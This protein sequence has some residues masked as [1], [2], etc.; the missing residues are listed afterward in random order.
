[1]FMSPKKKK[2]KEQKETAMQ[3]T[4]TAMQSME[5]SM[6]STET[7]R[8]STE[9]ARESTEIAIQSMETA[10]QSM[11][12]TM[13]SIKTNV[14]KFSYTVART[15][16]RQGYNL[17]WNIIEKGYNKSAPGKE[18]E[19]SYVT[20]EQ[21][22]SFLKGHILRT[23]CFQSERIFNRRGFNIYL[24]K[25]LYQV[26]DSIKARGVVYS[27]LHLSK[28]QK[29]KGVVTISSGSFAFILCH[30]THR[31]KIPVTVVLPTT[32]LEEKIKMYQTY[33]LSRVIVRGDTL[34]EAHY[35]AL[36]IAMREDLFY[37]DGNDH[38]NMIIGQA[39]LGIE[40][41]RQQS[42][43]DVV[44]LPT[45]IKGCGLTTAIAI[46]IKGCNSKITVIEVQGTNF[47]LFQEVKKQTDSPK[48]LNIPTKEYMACPLRNMPYCV[49]DRFISVTPE[50]IH[51]AS[52]HLHNFECYYDY[53]GSIA[54]AAI[55][56][57]HLDDL[58]GKRIVIPLYGRM[59]LSTED[60]VIDRRTFR[61]CDLAL[62][63]YNRGILHI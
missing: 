36:D 11:E 26:T 16:K 35:N 31:F 19:I 30:Y 1:M 56:S 45:T 21:A 60:F 3:S 7:A 6:Q 24:K 13:Q 34:L 42:Q 58:K 38:P 5:T 63:S 28:E 4:E 44:L 12:A 49:I 61:Q 55:L 46:A 9:S 62:I 50:L 33:P 41:V 47:D 14:L 20:I 52:M 25:E 29:C 17:A 27:L 51:S 57:G 8:E 59:D 39:T 22:R 43:I 48:E 40:I 23:P 53:Y 18:Y 37:L 10:I 2:Q 15:L 32:T 54:L